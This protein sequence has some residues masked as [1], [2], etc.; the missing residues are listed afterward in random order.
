[1]KTFLIEQTDRVR[2]GLRRYR[3]SS[4]DT[5]PVNGAYHNAYTPIGEAPIIWGESGGRRVMMGQPPVPHED[6]RW[7]ARCTC[8]YGFE[9][10]D[11]R[12]VFQEEIYRRVDTGEEMTLR[13]A[14]PGAMWDAWWMPFSRGPDGRCLVVKCPNGAE[15]MIDSR[16]SNCT[17]PDDNEHRCWVRHGEPPDITVDKNGL[18]CAAGAGSIQARD[19]HGFLR[20]GEFTP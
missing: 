8:G 7:P 9:P 12:Q 20:N 2:V 14:G 5:C 10:E 11:H 19:Y 16:A 18:T 15:W 4:K 13:E 1:M 3:D 6:P 17:L